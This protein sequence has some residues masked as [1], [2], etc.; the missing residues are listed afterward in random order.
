[1]DLGLKGR[2]AAITG[3]S[4]G[5]GF[6]IATALA[7]EGCNIALSA[8]GAQ[9]LDTALKELQGLGVKAVGVVTDF[10]TEEGCS[11]FVAEAAS[12]L[13]G[14]DILVN[15][16]GGLIPGTLD[17]LSAEQ[18]EKILNL[19]L[20]AAVHTTKHALPYLKK[21]KGARILNVSG[22]TGKQLLAGAWST[23]LTN[24]AIISFSKL[25]AAEVGAAG[26]TVN[27]ICPGFT[28]VK[29]WAPR[30]EAMAKARN[31]TADQVR[32]GIAGQTLLGRWAEPEEIGSVAAFLVSA[33]NSYMTGTTVE[34]CGG[35]TRYI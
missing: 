16:V 6:A 30:A 9:G 13:G 19:K 24:S 22:V 21:A 33:K 28:N 29:S 10:S 27:N 18:W 15:N 14:M 11:K 25:V 7:K 34:V 23:A 17:G 1:M 26:I 20:M 35:F 4:Q 32:A 31:I 5:I 3:S 2:N 8:R 12:Q